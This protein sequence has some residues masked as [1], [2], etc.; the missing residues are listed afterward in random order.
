MS[1]RARF[2]A[3]CLTL[4]IL[5]ACL[6]SGRPQVAAAEP[7]CSALTETIVHWLRLSETR[8]RPSLDRWCAGVGPSIVLDSAEASD[9]LTPPFAVVS[10]N[11]HVGA[12][13]L[14]VFIADLRAGRL[15]GKPV[16]DFVLLLQETYRS[17]SDVP[18]EL[19]VKWASA[20]FGAGP[21]S[22]RVEAMRVGERLGLSSMYVPSMRN[23]SPGVTAEDRGNA[24]LSTARLRDTGAIELPLERQRRVAVAATVM[25]RH[26]GAS[27]T[28]VRV[29]STHFTNMVMHHAW[30]LS[31]SGRL[32]QARA[33]VEA[34]PADGPMILG[35]DLNSW[36]GYRD[37]AYRQLAQRL[38]PAASE[39]RRATFG[40]MR[41]DHLLFRLPQGW[42]AELRRADRKYG[43]DH[44][45]LVALIEAQ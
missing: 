34:L 42:R 43:S 17:G 21:R 18:S 16:A 3:A 14:D 40:P 11:T 45:P 20:I 19:A 36:F 15:T 22:S 27:S 31:E 33:L 4:G 29:V 26:P 8:E 37:A 5:I 7:A 35:G 32:R 41:L 38:S 24:I 30:I 28:P 10:W 2:L 44:Y 13:D 25:V 6:G 23:G 12:G 39:D 9:A 1:S